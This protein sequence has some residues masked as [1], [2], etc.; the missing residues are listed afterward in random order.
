MFNQAPLFNT[1]QVA[2]KLGVSP[3]QISRLARS[4]QL[5][6]AVKAPG[7]R[8]AYLFAPAEVEHY[9][10]MR[11]LQTVGKTKAHPIKEVG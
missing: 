10:A 1:R 3:M 5:P 7:K 2:E 8:G 6:P 9:R 4:G 11:E